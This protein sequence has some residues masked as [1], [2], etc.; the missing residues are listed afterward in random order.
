VSRF[1]DR[2][3]PDRIV[4]RRNWGFSAHPLL[5]APDQSALRQP[6]AFH[7][8]HLWLRSERQTLRRLP[9]TGAIL[10]TIRVQLAPSA[11]LTRLPDL[12]ARLL[13]AIKDWTPELV[14]SR[15]GRYGWIDD[16]TAWLGSI[17][18]G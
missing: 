13:E 18:T 10:F 3:S 5:F 16:V 4:S 6:D 15:G 9:A 2:L 7:P 12:A 14:E 8:D 11:A 1:F 17:S